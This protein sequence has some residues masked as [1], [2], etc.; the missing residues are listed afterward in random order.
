MTT[1]SCPTRSRLY[2]GGTVV[3]EDFA[4]DDLGRLLDEHRD[5]VAWLDLLDPDEA[6]LQSI[7]AL[8]QL[9]PLAVEDAV[10]DHQRPK[11]DRYR[12]HLFLNVYAVHVDTGGPAPTVHKVEISAFVTERALITVRKSDSDIEPVTKRWDDDPG[13]AK[14]GVAFLLYGLL[15]VVVDGQ[16]GAARSLD[17]AIDKTEDAM[18]EEGGAP[19]STRMYGFGLRKA[20]AQLRRS[21]APMPDV[22]AMLLRPDL[23]LVV[24]GLKPYF[25]DIDDH[26]RR[27]TET[28]DNARERINSSLEAD[29]N[30]QSNQLN[31]ITRKLAAWAAI[32]A[33][34]TAI[35]GFF[36]QNVPFW[37]FERTGGFVASLVLIVVTG[38]SLYWYLKRRGWL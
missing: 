28:I 20:L 9:H 29:L 3:A 37:G 27:A 13:L 7:A 36:G 31:D 11:L 34:P 16:F 14:H 10:H 4:T 24:D 19:R 12:N 22:V 32:I 30:E 1:P 21:V 35:T 15:D 5:G 8:L 6:A 17:E 18:L 25:V 23:D 26:A 33:V 38:G 2:E